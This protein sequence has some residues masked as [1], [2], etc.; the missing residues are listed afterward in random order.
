VRPTP[1]STTTPSRVPIRL[2]TIGPDITAT[3]TFAEDDNINVDLE[4]PSGAE[5]IMPVA[6]GVNSLGT[7][8][9]ANWSGIN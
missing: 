1:C 4:A 8:C 2:P 9:W 5:A 6:V 7:D 3:T